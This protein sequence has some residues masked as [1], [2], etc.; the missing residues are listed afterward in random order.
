M[1]RLAALALVVLT[2]LA[3]PSLVSAQDVHVRDLGRFIGWRDNALVG[4]GLVTGLTGTGDSPRNPVTQRAISNVLGRLGL[5]IAPD[6]VRSRNVAAVMVTAVLSPSANVGDRI[7]VT[8]TSIGDARSL[9]GGVLLM[10]PLMAPDQRPYALA[11][12]ALVVGGY[13]FSSNQNAEQ[14]N[15]PTGGVISGGATIEVAVEARTLESN[16]E[17]IFV[18][19]EANFTTAVRTADAINL[20]TPGANARVTDADTIRIDARGAPDLYRLIA[21]IEE[22][23][24]NPGALARVVVN[25]RSGT[26][27]AGG[28]VRISSVTIAQGDVRVSV[29]QR[30]EASQP[31]VLGGLNEGVN[32]MVVTNTAIT[33]SENRDDATVTFPS[34]TVG[35]LMEGLS[36]LHIDTRGKISILQAIK[37]AGAL[38]AEIIV[39]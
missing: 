12:G 39:Q 3:T 25:E 38:H 33:V 13:Q 30:N 27:V 37:A 1:N 28:D 23:S 4:Y 15:F 6:D 21:Q 20:A 2:S 10:T 36:R 32:S 11:Q 31:V 24:V 29:Q 14:R 18:L 26:I 17:L 8:V 22:V 35:D 9:A 5:N 16:G 19:R 34:T 7:D